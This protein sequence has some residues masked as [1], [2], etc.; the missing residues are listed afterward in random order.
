[1]KIK[2]YFTKEELY[3]YLNYGETVYDA[4]IKAGI[5]INANCGGKGKCGKCKVKIIK[6]KTNK[7]TNNEISLLSIQ[8]V[9]KNIRLSCCTKIFDDIYVETLDKM[10]SCKMLTEENSKV[11]KLDPF[12]KVYNLKENL[13]NENARSFEE[14]II[15]NCKCEIKKISNEALRKFNNLNKISKKC[16]IYCSEEEIID[17]DA[18]GKNSCYGVA[19]DIGTTTIV[20]YLIDLKSGEKRDVGAMLN[21]QIVYGDDVITRIEYSQRDKGLEKLNL[22]VINALNKIIL[23][24]CKSQNI[25]YDKIY[26]C[27]IVGNTCMT[28]IFMG[29]PVESLGEYPYLPI[30]TKFKKIKAKERKIKINEEGYIYI[31]PN[32]SGFIGADIVSDLISSETY[33]TNKNFLIIDIGT[34]GEIVLGSK[35]HIICSS[36]AAGPAFEGSRIELGMR[37]QIGAIERFDPVTFEVKVIGNTIPQGICGSGLIDIISGLIQIGAVDKK[38]TFTGKFKERIFKKNNIKCFKIYEKQ[39]KIIYIT[40]KDIREFQM[41]KSAISTAIKLLLK[42]MDLKITDLDEILI[43]GAFGN[44]M[45]IENAISINIIPKIDLNKIKGIG[46]AAGAGAIKALLSRDFRDK[47]NEYAEKMKNINLTS[48]KEFYKMFIN[49]INF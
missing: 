14:Q 6:G 2:V 5:D 27:S 18:C 35:G 32:V 46:N 16:V 11:I 17:I 25:S 28:H 48:Y 20:G 12:V 34:N 37:G 41:A 13:F 42:E 21:P 4:A 8:D 22:S 40:Q 19:F 10:S 9:K 24:L 23:N 30:F 1:M 31:L 29:I 49:D 39:N 3:V 38:G 36:S 26:A 33:N 44:Y 7:I 15:K 47:C 45:D 43:A